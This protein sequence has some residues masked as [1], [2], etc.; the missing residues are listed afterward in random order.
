VPRSAFSAV[1]LTALVAGAGC[2]VGSDEEVAT[3]ERPPEAESRGDSGRAPLADRLRRGGYVL[4]FRHAATDF[5]MTDSTRDVR[6]CSRQRNLTGE[7]RR[8]ARSIGRQFRRLAIP[9]GRVLASPF[10]RTRETATLAFGR[11]VPSRALLS[12]EFFEGEPAGERQPARLRKLLA[13]PPRRATNTVLV[14]HNFAID[15][16]TGESLAEGE[17]V[18]VAPGR[19]PRGFEI[20]SRLE[21]GEWARL[22]PPAAGPPQVELREYKVFDG[23]GPHD[24][25]PAASGKVWFTA[26]AAGELGRLDPRTGRVR[27]VPLG[28]GSAP[29]GVIVG[30][31][32][33]A[34]VTDGGLNAIVRVD[35]RTLRVRRF[36]LPG[37]RAGAN[38]NTAT[39]DRRGRLWFTGQ[40]GVYG[41]LDP[42]SGRMRV[43][44][45]PRGAGPYGISTTRA[46]AVW[47]A[48]LAGSHIARIDTRSGR[49]RI[50]EPPTDGQGARRIW[51]D[52]RGRLWISEW[53][54]GKLGL[55][56]PH[57]RRWR[58][59]R[60]PGGNP[61]PYAVYVDEADLVWL[62]DFG[63]NS[64][65]RF[66]P[67]RQRFASF[68]LPQPG[69]NVRQLLGR[70]GE[71]WG[72]ES[73]TDRLVVALSRPPRT[74]SSDP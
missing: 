2:D 65:V 25:A 20:V 16:A 32:R 44:D 72:A 43:F 60:L 19:G 24:V 46:G 8:Q 4:A 17:A 9:V 35:A 12:A 67:A 14:S 69:A 37:D 34:W 5:S 73:G 11:A 7:G 66:D 52:S 71:V 27:R 18:I 74:T 3:T 57:T 1:V 61:Q 70:D 40:S 28:S 49:S 10:C 38:L 41:R 22:G 47:Y 55:Y 54:A 58:E 6:D 53:N 45:A 39:F 56:N 33:A 62:T 50:V 26:Q 29:H 23:A 42:R 68:R 31:D 48:S 21:A 30:P 63:A 15:D 59:W 64:L 51:P 36:P 13:S